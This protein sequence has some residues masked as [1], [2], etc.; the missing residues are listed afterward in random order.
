MKKLY[1][2]TTL[3]LIAILLMPSCRS[4]MGMTKRHYMKGY[5]VSH[6]KANNKTLATKAQTKHMEADKMTSV[7]VLSTKAKEITL[8]DQVNTQPKESIMASAFPKESKSTYS[9]SKVNYK[10]VA[11]NPQ[12]KQLKQALSKSNSGSRE[13]GLSLFWIII[14]VIL[15]LWL[16]GFLA[17]G[18]GLGGFINILLIIALI[19]LIL[20]LLRV[21]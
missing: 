8:N 7:N 14:L 11:I 6:T 18:L 20:W 12:V 19:L 2:Y 9:E 10:S 5:Y 17:G 15:I 1:T 3:C 21:V 13:D 4:K 16:L